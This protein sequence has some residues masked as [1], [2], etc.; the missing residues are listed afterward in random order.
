MKFMNVIKKFDSKEEMLSY[1]NQMLDE[2]EELLG[3][4]K[5][6]EYNAKMEDVKT[7]DAEYDQYKESMANIEALRGAAK[8]M[9]PAAKEGV[10]TAAGV[11][12]NQE[13]MEYGFVK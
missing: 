5:M 6:E 9:T 8:V 1:R 10:L 4:E 13:D 2:A 11:I 12:G 7:F 3:A